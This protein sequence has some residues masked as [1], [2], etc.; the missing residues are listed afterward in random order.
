MSKIEFKIGDT[1]IC[2][3]DCKNENRIKK[4]I[5]KWIGFFKDKE[6][7][8]EDISYWNEEK[9][10]IMY[11]IDNWSFV[12]TNETHNLHLPDFEEYFYTKQEIRRMKLNKLQN[13]RN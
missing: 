9:N 3:K 4:I 5:P 7:K 2:K 8:I 11:Q 6:Y 13:E 12:S 1:V 10:V